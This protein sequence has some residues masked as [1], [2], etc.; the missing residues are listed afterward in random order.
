MVFVTTVVIRQNRKNGFLEVEGSDGS[1]RPL[2]FCTIH[3]GKATVPYKEDWP[4]PATLT[5]HR[6]RECVD[7][8]N[9]L[10]AD[11]ANVTDSRGLTSTDFKPVERESTGENQLAYKGNLQLYT[12]DGDDPNEGV[13]SHLWEFATP[14][15]AEV[16]DD[17][18]GTV[19]VTARGP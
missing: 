8:W 9:P 4:N 7:D 19:G 2:Y 11:G 3:R 17:G 1:F 6:P 14:E 15:G 16:A 10:I 12:F 5:D 18:S 13:V